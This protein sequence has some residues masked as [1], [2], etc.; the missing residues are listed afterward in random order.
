MTDGSAG[1]ADWR[2]AALASALALVCLAGAWLLPMDQCPDEYARMLLPQWIVSTGTLPTGNELE[3]IIPLWGFSYALRPYLPAIASAGFMRLALLVT[4]S[5][6][7]QLFAAR[8]PSVICAVLLFV[9]CLRLGRRI[10][11]HRESAL[12]FATLVCFLPQVVFLGMYQNNDLPAITAVAAT[13]LCL[14]RGR[15]RSWDV[16]STVLLGVA[17]SAVALTYYYA[18]SWIIGAVVFCVASF[19]RDETIP[20]KPRFLARRVLLVLAVVVLLA[21]WHF[22]RTAL[23]QGGDFLGLASET[24]SRERM[25]AQGFELHEPLSLRAQGYSFA[26]FLAYKNGSFALL[27]MWSFVGLFGYMDLVLPGWLYDAY[28]V[29]IG[30]GLVFGAVAAIRVRLARSARGA[31]DANRT[32]QGLLLLAMLISCVI[33][34]ALHAWTSYARDFQP[35]GRYVITLILLVAYVIVYGLDSIGAFAPAPRGRHAKAEQ[36]GPA[37]PALAL[38]AI[39]IVLFVVSAATGMARMLP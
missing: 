1:K 25:S 13:V 24:T 18:Y 11:R 4:P 27:T 15:D 20:N 10:F 38:A 29:L 14:V 30:A 21:G 36:T 6:H 3:T 34:V 22:V 31:S 19:L 33:T 32:G 26:E 9:F 7:V 8:I 16:P 2:G 23:N 17:I 5:E 37:W 28:A 39:W 35:Q 12:S